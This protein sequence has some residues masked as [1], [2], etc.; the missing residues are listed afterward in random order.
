VVQE[1]GC[2]QGKEGIWFDVARGGQGDTGRS[3]GRWPSAWES[4]VVMCEGECSKC[5][6]SRECGGACSK[7]KKAQWCVQRVWEVQ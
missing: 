6:V 7:H 2:R 3:V 1:Q 5:G 4:G